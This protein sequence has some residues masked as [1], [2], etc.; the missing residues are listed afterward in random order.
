MTARTS[1]T[2]PLQIAELPAGAGRVGVSFCPGKQQRDGWSGAWARDLGVDLDAIR[3]WGADAVVTLVEEHELAALKVE[4]MGEGVAA[5]GMR[6]F[7]LPIRDV[8]T[9]CAR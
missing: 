9:P 8:Q 3:A 1:A 4:G 7:H 5:R 6:W 2:H